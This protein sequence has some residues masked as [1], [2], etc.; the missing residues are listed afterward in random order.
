MRDSYSK[1]PTNMARVSGTG[2]FG[3]RSSDE[4]GRGFR[5][6]AKDGKVGGWRLSEG[7]GATCGMLLGC[8]ERTRVNRELGERKGEAQEKV[9]EVSVGNKAV[10]LSCGV[11]RNRACRR[12]TVQLYNSYQTTGFKKK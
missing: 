12:L 10:L 2:T 7:S 8:I 6:G 5:E 1:F 4:G 3:L 11:H 9:D